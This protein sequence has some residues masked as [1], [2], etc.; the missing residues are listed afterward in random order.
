M[1]AASQ[2]TVILMKVSLSKLEGMTREERGQTLDALT[3]ASG[4]GTSSVSEEVKAFEDKYGMS[5][6]EMKEKVATGEMKET[7]EIS[8][9][10]FLLNAPAQHP[11]R[12]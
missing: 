3:E 8:K 5:S 7:P 2:P 4:D 11:S 9:W 12:T 1:H 6:A 10:L